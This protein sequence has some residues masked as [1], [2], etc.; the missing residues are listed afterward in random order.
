MPSAKHIPRGIFPNEP[1]TFEAILK[2]SSEGI[3]SDDQYAIDEFIQ[4][5][6]LQRLRDERLVK[7]A[8]ES[9]VQLTEETFLSSDRKKIIQDDIQRI[10][11]ETNDLINEIIHTNIFEELVGVVEK[12][13]VGPIEETSL[14]SNRKTII[15]NDIIVIAG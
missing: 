11:S 10:L 14:S 15:Q 12:P 6:V 4:A 9:D 2:W 13:F 1:M 5:N 8:E 3:S 7:L